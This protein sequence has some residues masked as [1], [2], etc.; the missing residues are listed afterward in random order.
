V[1]TASLELFGQAQVLDQGFS[2]GRGS[3][4]AGFST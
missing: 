2:V 4:I 1:A 3:L